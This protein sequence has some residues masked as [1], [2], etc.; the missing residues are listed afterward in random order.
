MP[1]RESAIANQQPYCHQQN[2]VQASR[3]LVEID[4]EMTPPMNGPLAMT[5]CFESSDPKPFGVT[6]VP[7]LQ[8]L[9]IAQNKENFLG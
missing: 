7:E 9:E 5:R 3:G 4:G 8:M 2:C 6:A 1:P